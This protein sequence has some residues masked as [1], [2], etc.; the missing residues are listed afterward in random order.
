MIYKEKTCVVCNTMYIPTGRNS[1]YCSVCKPAQTKLINK[2]A[3]KNW[4]YKKGILNGKGS[5]SN[6]GFEKENH[7]YSHGQ[8]TFRRWA[9]E[10]KESD[11]GFCAHCNK[12]LRLLTHY[13]WVG[14]HKDHNRMNN[15]KENLI[16][17][18]KKCHQ[19]EH[20]C[21]K[22]FESVTTISKESRVDN[23]PKRLA[24]EMDDDI[25][26]SS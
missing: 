2:Q 1:K 10:L 5:G 14:H 25:V 24:P 8:C 21:W 22:A 26:C 4:A 16:L 11:K 20:Q 15:T 13:E 6:T 9:K 12:D 19:I 23:N 7:M 17:L 18:C 3:V